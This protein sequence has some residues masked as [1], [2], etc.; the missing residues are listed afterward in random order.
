[1]R[2]GMVKPAVSGLGGQA[3]MKAKWWHMKT[4]DIRDKSMA[5]GEGEGGEV[6]ARATAIA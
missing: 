4:G 2:M 3:Y 6:Q 1:M 5:E